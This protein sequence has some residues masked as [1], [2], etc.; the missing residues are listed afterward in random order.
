MNTLRY[1][2]VINPA[3]GHQREAW[4]ESV[5]LEMRRLGVTPD[6]YQTR[7]PGDAIHHLQQLPD[8]Y[9]V[10]IPAGGDGTINEVINGMKGKKAVLGLIPGGT[11][12]VLATEL[13]Y[14]QA[15]EAVANVLVNGRESLIHLARLND[16]RFCMMAGIGYDARVV[17]GVDLAIKKKHGKLAYILSM[18]QQLKHFGKARYV[19]RLENSAHAASSLVITKGQHYGG[20]Y[21]LTRQTTLQAPAL[22]ILLIQTSSRL[23]FLGMLLLLPFGLVE[24]LSFIKSLSST[25]LHVEAHGGPT[26]ESVQADGDTVSCLPAEILVEEQPTRVLVPS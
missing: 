20:P 13:G 10:I 7:A 6:V 1:L 12:N 17:A 3:A 16:H 23:K 2:V 19:V 4:V 21:I 26:N 8:I 15:P 9:D 5:I 18:L 24:K 14:P 25:R 22:Q 11:S